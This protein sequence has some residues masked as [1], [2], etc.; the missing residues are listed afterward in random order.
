MLEQKILE[1]EKIID[2]YQQGLFRF[3]FFRTGSTDDS[4]DI[5][6]SV[7]LRLHERHGNLAAIENIKSYL[8]R[9]VANACSDLHRR[10]QSI[11]KVPL[12]H[13]AIHTGEPAD[14][15][16]LVT[17]EQEYIRINTLLDTLPGEQAEVIRMRTTDDLS[18]IEIADIL[19]I[20]P[21]TAKSRFRYGIE[22]LRSNLSKN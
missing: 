21:A 15:D 20:P 7:F 14:Y 1:L 6:Q 9:A 10:K 3:A 22:K 8:Y 4:A 5:V 19:Q 13:A 18:F 12:V 2:T 16:A 11:R 17:A